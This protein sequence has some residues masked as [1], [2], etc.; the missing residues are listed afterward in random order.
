MFQ[1]TVDNKIFYTSSAPNYVKKKSSSGAW[2]P[3]T[4]N[5]AE[6]LAFMGEIYSL[7]NKQPIENKP[8][9][10]V[11][12]IDG[13]SIIFQVSKQTA[14]NALKVVDIQEALCD[15]SIELEELKNG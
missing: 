13:G 2:I 15:L 4:K 9:A 5:D 1:I 6:G 12:E 10:V 7:P 3:A 14:D 11:K 8:V